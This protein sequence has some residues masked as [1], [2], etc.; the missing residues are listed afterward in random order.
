[1]AGSSATVRVE[2]A[3]VS[4]ADRGYD[5]HIGPGLL[6]N[7]VERCASCT[8]LHHVIVITDDTVAP[9]YG[10]TVHQRFIDAGVAAH[11]STVPAGEG[12]KSIE[13]ATRLWHE[14]LACGANR[15]S[16][17]V[18]VGGGVVGDLA[19]FVA[20]SF[21]RGLVFIQIPT[22]LLAQVDSS[23]GGKVAV[24]LPGAKN[25]VG[26]FWQPKLVLADLDALDTLPQREYASGLAEVVKYGVIADAALFEQLEDAAP[27]ILARDKTVLAPLV[28]R[29]CQIKADVVGQDERETSGR[30]AIL[31]YG[32]TIG[33]AL[34]S[35]CGYGQL[36]HGEAIAI[37]MHCAALL[38]AQRK[39]V[40]AEFV[41]RQQALLTAFQLP[42]RAPKLDQTALW[43]AIAKDKKANAFGARFILPF[44]LGQ[45]QFVEGVDQREVLLV[46]P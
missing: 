44:G 37:G 16:T 21:A 45:V 33:H 26:F 36:L 38:A 20:A 22:T 14:A 2:F 25:M 18:A 35:V 19:G 41:Q 46:W 13:M 24:N 30:R 6:G 43:D 23:V 3:E 31:N 8:A 12:S 11:L 39:M 34:E 10:Q 4:P 9:L 17:V 40:S 32:H 28:A 7:A 15:H 1:L 27:A 42:I 29:C 5:I